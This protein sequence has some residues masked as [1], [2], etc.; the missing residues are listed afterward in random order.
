MQ[1]LST[2][3]MSAPA[4]QK[5]ADHVA[6]M[7]QSRYPGKLPSINPGSSLLKLFNK[8]ACAEAFLNDT[9]QRKEGVQG[10]VKPIHSEGVSAAIEWRVQDQADG[11]YTG[12]FKTG[13][14]GIIRLSRALN[15]DPFTPGL[16]VKMFVD[17]LPSVNFH[18]M[19]S[20]DGQGTEYDFFKNPFTTH[21]AAPKR[22]V[23][24][25]LAYFF[26]RSFP[27]ISDRVQ[28]RPVDETFMP[29]IEAASVEPNG[30]LV[31]E[32]VAPRELKL[33]PQVSVRVLDPNA[34]REAII[35]QV[36]GDT[37]LYQVLDE[38]GK[39]IANIDLTGEFIASAHGD[40]MAFKHQR[41]SSV[42]SLAGTACPFVK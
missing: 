37:T 14:V 33:M 4:T 13:G 7:K 35:E 38:D 40:E 27:V 32:P 23:L 2:S 30:T 16:A 26:R 11:R 15:S 39:H 36:K 6:M 17:G 22:T 3:S 34:F 8:K 31:A 1:N 19:Y 5:L 42:A 24:K 20:L 21:V 25:V 10:A 9:D 18:A 28:G 41:I 12:V 29:L